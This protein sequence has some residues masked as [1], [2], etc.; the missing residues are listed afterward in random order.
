M[1]ATADKSLQSTLNW[2]LQRMR[3]KGFV[4]N[5]RV[6]LAIDPK[7]AIMGYAKKEGE[8]HKIVISDWALD[9]E[10]LGG[11]VLHELAHIYFTER[12]AH[13]H[14]SQALERILEEMKEQDGLRA[15]EVE[16]L[17][18]AYNHLQNILV[19][20]IVFAVMQSKELEVAK[21]FF[22]EWVSDKP[23]GDPVLD[24]SL[25]CRN[26]FAIASLSRRRL[27]DRESEIV[28]RN[29]GFLAAMGEFS[30]RE[31]GWM[32]S[33]L[34]GARSDWSE[35]E[36]TVAMGEYLDKVL[37]LMRPESKLADLR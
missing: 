2:A 32:E 11:L 13:S 21:R 3:G 17:V 9:S 7:L 8:A 5:S 30:E 12:G 15:K 14:D 37:S 27:L 1:K 31:F 25:L 16:N 19:D 33:F 26:A 23:S 6:S 18:D 24:A 28:Y 34:E 35:M 36:F 10:M 22:S 4:I 20:D 29:K